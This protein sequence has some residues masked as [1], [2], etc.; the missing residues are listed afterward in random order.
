MRALLPA[1]LL[2]ATV[3][4]AQAAPKPVPEEGR[5]YWVVSLDSLALGRVAH[6][7]VRVTGRLTAKRWQTDGD[8]HLHLTSAHHFIIGECIPTGCGNCKALDQAGMFK[9][10]QMV[11]LLGIT[12]YDREHGWWELHPVESVVE[13][14]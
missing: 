9:V 7:H 1:L 11:T 14:R 8:L 10:G 3:A 6:T 13:V 4:H 12:R 5:R 2:F